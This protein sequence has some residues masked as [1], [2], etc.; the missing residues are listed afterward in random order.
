M[1]ADLT[2]ENIGA[3]VAG[4]IAVIGAIGVAASRAARRDPTPPTPASSAGSLLVLDTAQAKAIADAL[5]LATVQ[6]VALA[7]VV[8]ANTENGEDLAREAERLGREMRD[9]ADRLRRESH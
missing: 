8:E 9:L 5:G 1:A 7:K 6:M 2:P 3:L 4:A